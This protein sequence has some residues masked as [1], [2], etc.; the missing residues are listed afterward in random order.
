VTLERVAQAVLERG[1]SEAEQ[2][3]A[4]AREEKERM[5]SEARV[6]GE[7]NVKAAQA[8]ARDEAEHRKVQEVARAE[9][10]ARKISLA[11]Q[12]ETL[13]EV[14]KRALARL[15]E[16]KEN[17]E[18]LKGL[19]KANESEWKAGGHVYSNKKDESV[20]RKIVGSAYAG[21]IDCA[22]GIVIESADGTR[23]IDLRYDSLLSE[24]WDDAVREVAE[25]LWPQKTS[26]G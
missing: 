17:K 22:G 8:Q 26:K 9:L 20:V 18:I 4:Q 21:H 7:A 10:E 12:K 11:A 1:K 2:I 16:L 15:H 24:V 6:E 23:R 14:Y 5:L 13:D 3:V 25:V 19:L